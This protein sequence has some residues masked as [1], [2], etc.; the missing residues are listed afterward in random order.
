MFIVQQ[1]DKYIKE[2]TH[3]CNRTI[4]DSF[5]ISHRGISYK[6]FI[7]ELAIGHIMR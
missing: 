6:E 7:L 2:C 3:K 5:S 1:M 4:L